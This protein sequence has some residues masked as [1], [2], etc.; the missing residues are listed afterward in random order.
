M[1]RNRLKLWLYMLLFLL[2]GAANLYVLTG[3]LAA[4]ALKEADTGLRVGAAHLH[5]A[6]R[7]MASEAAAVTGLAVKSAELLEALFAAPPRADSAKKK[8]KGPPPS[9]AA[10]EAAV[11]ARY[12]A[13]ESAARNAVEEAAQRLAISL[14]AGAWWA[15]ASPEWLQKKLDEA[16]Q[17]PQRKEAAAFL[18]DAAGG[19]PRR[20]YVRVNDGLWY[21]V[22]Y[23]AGEGAALVLFLPL[24]LGWAKT[25]ASAAGVDLTLDVGT[26][27]L[28]TTAAPDLA[29]RLARTAATAS[30]PVSEGAM[31][32]VMLDQ[33][34]QVRVPVLFTTAPAAR[35]LSVQ[36]AGLP[37]GH[38]ILSIPTVGFFTELARYQWALLL[39]M[40]A[41]GVIGLLLGV[42]VKTEVLPQVPATLVAAA[43]KIERGDYSAR[44][45]EFLGA[46]GTVAGAL[47]KA[48]EVAEAATS[49]SGQDPFAPPGGPNFV[50]PKEPSFVFP[51]APP[52][53]PQAQAPAAP[54][55]STLPGF[56]P[57]APGEQV[58]RD[59]TAPIGVSAGPAAFPFPP[60][61][62]PRPS[63]PAPT[64]LFQAVTPPAVAE[65]SEDEHW[66]AV[67]QEFLRVRSECGEPTEG[68]GF[69]RFKPKLEKNREQLM[70]RHGCRTVRFS[71]YVKDGKAALRATP[72]K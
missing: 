19:N 46:L 20:G 56:A 38:M 64:S 62:Q 33:P 12:A 39:G 34:V 10:T 13:A 4:M 72:V 31:P 28:I 23:P 65:E 22:A 47:N 43:A 24:D 17:D 45:P 59:T 55:P 30:V 51:I 9:D 6:E 15:V 54:P 67:H 44:A 32:L 8:G 49:R 58:A 37:K 29:K 26:P 41:L 50:L 35:A 69:D 27:Q 3:D 68:L 61:P 70:Q 52:F 16:L 48:A 2:A 71:V 11:Q 7:L 53:Q 63:G 60:A 57:P 21:G 14:P 42:L 25:M 66:R 36:L 18:R 40:A 5:E 1:N